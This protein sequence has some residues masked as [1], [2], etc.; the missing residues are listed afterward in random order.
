MSTSPAYIP[1]GAQD[2]DVEDIRTVADAL[3]ASV[4]ARGPTTVAFEAAVARVVHAPH[5]VT[6]SSG[7]AGLHLACLAAGI[8]PGDEVITSPITFVASANCA[9]YC[10]A[11]PVFADVEPDTACIDPR[12]IAAK[13]TP[14]THAVVPV[15]FAGQSCDMDAIVRVVR[16]AEQRFGRKIWI[17]EDACHVL[18]STYRGEPIGSCA[19]GDM[20]VF[21]FHPVKHATTGEGGAIA[22]RDA[23]TDGLLR[24]LRGHGMTKDPALLSQQPGPWYYEQVTLGYNYFLTDFQAALGLSQLKKLPRFIARRATIVAKYDAAFADFPH[25]HPLARRPDTT[26]NFHVYILR[27]NFAALGTTRAAVMATFHERG[28]QTQVHYIPVT[29]QPYYRQRYGTAPGDCPIADA[30]YDQC[31]TIPLFPK[32]S[33]EDVERVIAAVRATVHSYAK[34]HA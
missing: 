14:R 3:A 34:Q 11:T 15:H 20:A 21:S 7:T 22:T 5:V 25:L 9:A 10:G 8:G 16:D 18:G 6:C 32:M 13:I 12:A 19:Y 27:M 23:A 33:D 1:Y 28:I 31:L 30:Y 26:T 17:I 4:I 2:I 29:H 24:R